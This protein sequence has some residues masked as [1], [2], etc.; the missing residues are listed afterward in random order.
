MISKD[1]F[2]Q[3]VDGDAVAFEKLIAEYEQL[4]FSI[5]LRML[6]NQWDARDAA[7]DTIIKIWKNIHK[8][9]ELQ[10]FK[11][12]SCAIANNTCIDELRKRK[13]QVNES[14]SRIYESE[15][16]DYEVQYESKDLGPEEIYAAKVKQNV[17]LE[18]IDKLPLKYKSLIIMRDIEGLSYE[19]LAVAAGLTMGTVKSRLSR[20]R[21]KLRTLL[22]KD[23]LQQ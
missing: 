2:R 16:N 15:E 3:A 5:C 22:P 21:E 17:I 14:L 6:G 10:S 18:A 23:I 8:C 13:K 7:Q 9:R 4:I 11:S 20:A 1:I 19:D 12:W